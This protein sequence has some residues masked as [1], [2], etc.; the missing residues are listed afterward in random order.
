M[1][2]ITAVDPKV[3][4]IEEI[5]NSSLSVVDSTG[6]YVTD[7]KPGYDNLDTGYHVRL[8]YLLGM[9]LSPH[10]LKLI[11]KRLS[12]ISLLVNHIGV[13]SDPDRIESPYD[14]VFLHLQLSQLS[15]PH[16]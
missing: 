15:E 4:G 3:L 2:S 10:E 14:K 1:T 8:C 9:C 11:H 5:V 7:V 6:A 16:R 12:K 13:G